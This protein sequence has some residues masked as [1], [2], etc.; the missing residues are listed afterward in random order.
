MHHDASNEINHNTYQWC[1]VG[2]PMESSTLLIAHKD[3]DADI[4][5]GPFGSLAL[6]FFI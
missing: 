5:A 4:V 3:G 2:K 1:I 6:E